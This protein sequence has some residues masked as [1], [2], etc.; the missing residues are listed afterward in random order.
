MGVLRFGVSIEE[1]LLSSFDS[2]ISKREYVTRS[3]AIRDLIRDQLIQD[4]LATSQQELEVLASLTLIYDHHTYDLIKR[5]SGIQHDHEELVISVM[6]VHI[7]RDDCMEII[8]LRG[9]GAEVHSLA[10]SLLS[11]KG[12]K[13]GKLF[14][15]LPSH[16]ML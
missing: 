4:K 10:D 15:T 5:M 16:L 8:V 11:L 2:L 7:S 12:V 3:E 14:I 6:H 13:H 9:P 1:K